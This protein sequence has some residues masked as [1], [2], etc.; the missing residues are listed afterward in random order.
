MD[1][2]IRDN[3][4][5]E[6]VQYRENYADSLVDNL[7][8][9]IDRLCCQKDIIAIIEGKK[10]E[11]KLVKEAADDAGGWLSD[12]EGSVLYALAQKCAGRGVIVEIGSYK[13][14]ST[15]YLG[16]GS[17]AGK[18]VKI[19]AIDPHREPFQRKED[20]TGTYEKFKTNIENAQL[21]GLV[22]PIVGTS[23][24]AA[25]L[26]SKPCELLVID[27]CHKYDYVQ[28]DF[29]TWFPKVIDGGIIAFHD[30]L[31]GGPRKVVKE[32][33]Y[34]SKTF[35]KVGFAG[36]LTFGEKTKANSMLERLK[37]RYVFVMGSFYAF[38]IARNDELRRLVSVLK[39][40]SV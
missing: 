7:R 32:S 12:I 24:E 5:S 33:L 16:K 21:R 31:S 25:S 35:R 39:Q 6:G 36:S 3:R 15:I 2:R 30:T 10:E 26:I 17:R 23:S 13:G 38:I 28:K 29:D 8:A 27:G 11:L 4:S 14:K 19:Y 1:N 40:S 37:N 20:A 34:R 9:K 18:N 22:N